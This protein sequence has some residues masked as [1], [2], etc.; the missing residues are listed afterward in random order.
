M[1]TSVL[2]VG[3]VNMQNSNVECCLQDSRIS[4]AAHECVVSLAS[5]RE[6]WSSTTIARHTLLPHYLATRLITS[7]DA[8]PEDT[9]PAL[10]E[11]VSVQNPK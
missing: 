1:V 4:A 9:E 10:I 6:V 2:S 8:I 11:D 7:S 3:L 5:V